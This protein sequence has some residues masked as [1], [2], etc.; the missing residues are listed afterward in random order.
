MARVRRILHPSDFSRA[1]TA[2][3]RRAVEMAKRE[4][5]ELLLAHV[6]AP[7]MTLPPEGYVSPKLY[8]ELETSNR[9]AAQKHLDG[10]VAKAKKAGARAT[11]FLLEGTPAERIAQA[12]RSRRADLIIIGT[13]GRTGLARFFLGSVAARVVAIASCPVLTVRG[14]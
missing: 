1:S 6:L 7:V 2:A 12:A 11:G 4:G 5:A 9:G 8:E 3:F 10:L 13:H 14:K